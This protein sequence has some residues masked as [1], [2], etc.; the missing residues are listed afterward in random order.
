ME[1]LLQACAEAAAASDRLSEEGQ[2][3]RMNPG[4]LKIFQAAI[5]EEL[6]GSFAFRFPD[7]NGDPMRV[8]DVE[9]DA[10]VASRGEWLI[11]CWNA[12]ARGNRISK[13]E[14]VGGEAAPEIPS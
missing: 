1:Q 12:S 9:I 5:A 10:F 13:K 6:R 2:A 14:D 3:L 4:G 11:D 8:T 7:A